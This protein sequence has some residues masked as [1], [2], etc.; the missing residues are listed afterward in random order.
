MAFAVD[1]KVLRSSLLESYKIDGGVGSENGVKV[2][3]ARI[4]IEI[5]SFCLPDVDGFWPCR[6][7]VSEPD[8]CL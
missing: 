3:K 6:K 8:K 4:P 7:G 1:V 5:S 2:Y